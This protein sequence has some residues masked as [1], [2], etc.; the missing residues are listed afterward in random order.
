MKLIRYGHPGFERPGCM[1]AQGQIRDLSGEIDDI[2]PQALHPDSLARLVTLD[3]STLPVIKQPIRI[4][5]P[6]SGTG[7]FIG[8]GLNYR[9]HAEETGSDI[10]DEPILFTKWCKPTGPNDTVVLP[11]SSEKTDW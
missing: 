2:D 11:P 1:D 10:P 7:K 8:I 6:W 5:A 9:D 3:T 4:A